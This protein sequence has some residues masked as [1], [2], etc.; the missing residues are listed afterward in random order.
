MRLIKSHCGLW[1]TGDAKKVH[2]IDAVGS[3]WHKSRIFLKSG[4]KVTRIYYAILIF[5]LINEIY[6]DLHVHIL[7]YL[8]I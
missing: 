7:I 2:K 6:F 3:T 4:K 5:D 8:L 1:L